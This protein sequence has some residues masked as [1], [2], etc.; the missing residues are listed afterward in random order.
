M[1]CLQCDQE[2][3]GV[4]KFCG[5]GVCAAHAKRARFVSGA[6]TV[7]NPGTALVV[8]EFLDYVIV[9]NALWCGTCTIRPV[10]SG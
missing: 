2:D 1:R 7:R 4:C 10:Y 5:S 3:R 6:G 8:R 9:D